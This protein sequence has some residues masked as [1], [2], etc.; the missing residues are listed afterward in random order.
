M[1]L[2]TL[3]LLACAGK[4]SP[5]DSDTG[6]DCTPS[7]WYADTDNDGYGAGTAVS[8]CLAPTA[9]VAVDG[10]C[11]D[12]NAT[13]H[14]GAEE[15]CNGED[16]D[17][18]G[19]ADP[20]DLLP[21]LTCYRDMDEDGWGVE[22]ST[23]ESCACPTGYATQAGDC[24]DG[25]AAVNPGAAEVWYDGLDQDCVEQD[26]FD[27]DA[28]GWQVDED[29]DDVDPA[30]N[31]DAEEVCGNGIDDDCDGLPGACG[32]DADWDVTDA[33]LEILSMNAEAYASPL[34]TM[35]DV[36]G[37]GQPELALGWWTPSSQGCG[38]GETFFEVHVTSLAASGTEAAGD[39][40]LA[41]LVAPVDCRSGRWEVYSGG[42]IADQDLDG[43]GHADTLVTVP[44]SASSDDTLVSA[45]LYLAHGPVVGE[46]NLEDEAYLSDTASPHFLSGGKAGSGVQLGSPDADGHPTILLTTQTQSN[47]PGLASVRFVTSDTFLHA[48]ALDSAAALTMPDGWNLTMQSVLDFDGDGVRDLLVGLHSEDATSWATFL[49]PFDRDLEPSDA[50][51]EVRADDDPSAELHTYAIGCP[52]AT[53]QAMVSAWV[54]WTDPGTSGPTYRTS[55]SLAWPYVDGVQDL[56]DSVN[57]IF[58][59]DDYAPYVVSCT[60]DMDANGAPELVLTDNGD[61]TVDEETSRVLMFAD[62]PEPGSWYIDDIVR[63]Q[64]VGPSDREWRW[65]PNPPLFADVDFTGDGADDLVIGLDIEPAWYEPEETGWHRTLMFPGSPAGL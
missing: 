11:D 18:D 19:E 57:Q 38:E 23:F 31:P 28:D 44:N 41:K 1:P 6:D 52:T 13:V 32:L 47:L 64:V 63:G 40:S 21:V 24:D 7:S 60:G 9:H 46:V 35:A 14:P 33:R 54:E 53:G 50:D 42:V 48:E 51:G 39:R 45:R 10:D 61:N 29:C 30:V 27:A 26:E 20:P 49:G 37:D 15:I 55:A 36:D 59:E 16:D 34:G 25:D 2:V 4:P 56:S 17:C 12:S 58:S 22:D 8:A 65:Y 3:F 5:V 62:Q 43:D